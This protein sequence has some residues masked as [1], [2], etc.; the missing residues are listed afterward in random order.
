MDFKAMM[1]PV[2]FGKPPADEVPT[3]LLRR[4]SASRRLAALHEAAEVLAVLP[5]PGE[6]LH[7][8]QTGRYDLAD[9]VDVILTKLG[10]VRHLRIAT[11]SFNGRNVER[12]KAWTGPGGAAL[13]VSLLCSRF[14]TEHN[15]DLF[16]EARQVLSPPHRLAASRSHI[17]V[18]TWELADGGKLALEGSANLRTNSNKEQFCIF[19]DAELHDWHSAWIDAEVTKHE[20]DE[21]HRPAAG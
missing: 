5:G 21:S 14:L 4:Q 16:L 9:L 18:I 19:N 13:Q 1:K 11:L 7:A 17:K 15:P 3:P 6:A 20:G 10:T 2:R 12:L 8:I